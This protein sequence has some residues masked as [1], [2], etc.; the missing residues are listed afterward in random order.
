MK[1][2]G[3]K[4]SNSS[5]FQ[6]LK[7][8]T[9]VDLLVQKAEKFEGKD[10]IRRSRVL[11][12]IPPHVIIE[13]PNL[14]LSP[15]RIG[16]TIDV[17]YLF[18]DKDGSKK[19][20]MVK[21][22]L[23]DITPY[24][25]KETF[26]EAL[27]CVPSSDISRGTLRRHYR[28]EVPQDENVVIKITDLGRKHIGLQPTYKI[29][30]LSLQGLKFLCP[31]IVHYKGKHVRDPVGKLSVG[32]EILVKLFINDE[33]I[34]WAKNAIRTKIVHDEKQSDVIYFG[35]EFQKALIREEKTEKIRFETYAEKH[36]TALLP[37]ITDLQRK[38]LKKQNEL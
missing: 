13:Q 16:D 21:M 12:I 27:F 38:L 7:P 31:R 9:I 32:D 10:D 2:K 29:L 14:T 4:V 34:L 5:I 35:V 28:V 20:A 15:R 37:Y 24:Q 23:A 36:R 8:T 18:N 17:T 30:D 6:K 26:T 22:E 3:G 33:E 19:R 1:K 25:L 11:D